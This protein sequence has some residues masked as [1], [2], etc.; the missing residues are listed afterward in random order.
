MAT[1]FEVMN[2]IFIKNKEYQYD[3]KDA[4]AYI[5]ALWFSQDNRL[6]DLVNSVNYYQFIL[7]D[8]LVYQYYFHAIPKGK[9]FLKWT[10]KDKVDKKRDA[11]IKQL[12]E[13]HDCSIMEIKKSLI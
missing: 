10:K 12:S 2:N 1:L 13:K 7:P 5:L 9:R 4:G 8:E 11:I 3:K 6:L